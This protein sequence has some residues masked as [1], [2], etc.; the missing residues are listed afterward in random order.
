MSFY[1]GVGNRLHGEKGFS[2]YQEALS[3][4]GRILDGG[5]IDSSQVTIVEA[6]NG[7]EALRKI[8]EWHKYR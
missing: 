8:T 2:G 6:F 4:Q 5:D 3:E 7:T 1:V